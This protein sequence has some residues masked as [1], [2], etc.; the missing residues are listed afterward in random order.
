MIDNKLWKQLVLQWSELL[1]SGEWP[2]PRILLVTEFPAASQRFVPEE[3][4]SIAACPAAVM[5]ELCLGM[6]PY[7]PE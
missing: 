7:K 1:V 5:S 3:R 2:T 6:L 4:N